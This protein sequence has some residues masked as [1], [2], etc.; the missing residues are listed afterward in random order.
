MW[1]SGEPRSSLLDI[2]IWDSTG[3][4]IRPEAAVFDPFSNTKYVTFIKMLKMNT[5]I[6]NSAISQHAVSCE[7]DAIV[8]QSF[9]KFNHRF[10]I[11]QTET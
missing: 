6:A 3:T 4:N 8:A 11:V 1:S 5:V 7:I 9:D 10:T 2:R